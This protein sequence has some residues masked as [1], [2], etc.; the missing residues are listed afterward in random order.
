MKLLWLNPET[1]TFIWSRGGSP[2]AFH[3]L[4]ISL[5]GGTGHRLLNVFCQW[6]ETN[7]A[8]EKNTLRFIT[9]TQKLLLQQFLYVYK[10]IHKKRHI[11]VVH[12]IPSFLA[13]WVYLCP[14]RQR[15]QGV[16]R[17]VRLRSVSPGWQSGVQQWPFE[18]GSSEF[19]KG[20]EPLKSGR[21]GEPQCS[22]I[23][24]VLFLEQRASVG[25]GVFF[26]SQP[27]NRRSRA[28][29]RDSHL[30]QVC[31]RTKLTGPDVYWWRDYT[32]RGRW[33]QATVLTLCMF[34]I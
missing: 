30:L 8:R 19:T 7:M 9:T 16:C 4:K 15:V 18:K 28:S 22:I 23:F 1:Q 14:L 21:D 27:G 6:T 2:A 26:M 31:L 34:L 13:S 25:S 17:V 24:S 20:A 3:S 5:C 11:F 29:R 32:R 12:K 33:T 10:A